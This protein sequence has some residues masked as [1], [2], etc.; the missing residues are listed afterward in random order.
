M[1]V[2]TLSRHASIAISFSMANSGNPVQI[3]R[4]REI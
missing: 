3:V 4:L 1:A 2:L